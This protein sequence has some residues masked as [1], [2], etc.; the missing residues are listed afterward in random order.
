MFVVKPDQGVGDDGRSGDVDQRGRFEHEYR[1][2]PIRR[3]IFAGE[4][5]DAGRHKRR[6]KSENPTHVYFHCHFPGHPWTEIRTVDG[7]QSTA[8]CSVWARSIPSEEA[9]KVRFRRCRHTPCMLEFGM[10]PHQR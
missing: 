8:D 10:A 3:S 9:V 7:L 5:T 4:I 2:K 1:I 6:N